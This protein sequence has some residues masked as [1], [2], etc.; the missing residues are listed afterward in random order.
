MMKSPASAPL[1]KRLVLLGGGHSHLSVLKYLAMHPVPG[2]EVVLISKDIHTPYSGALP[3][4]IAGIYNH[5]DIHIDLRP[6]AQF[7]GARLIREEI[8]RIDLERQLV[9]CKD[10]PALRFDVLSINIGSQPDAT[11]IPGAQQYALGVKPMDLFLQSW[12]QV[13]EA[14][15][16]SVRTGKHYS[17]AIVGGGPASVELAFSAQFRIHKEA[18]IKSSANSPLQIK[19]IT[20]D[21]HLLNS[22][23]HKVQEFAQAELQRRGI[24]ILFNHRVTEFGRNSIHC[25]DKPTVAAD[26]IIY[27]TGASILQWPTECGLAASADGFIEV[28]T[29]LQSTSHPSVFACGDAATIAGYPRPKSGVFAVRHGRPLAENLVRFATGRSLKKF[30]PQKHALALMYT[31]DR[32]AIASK[33]QW[34]FHGAWVWLWKDRIDMAFMRKYAQLP[35]MKAEFSLATG[36]TDKKTEQELR[37]HAI[38]CMGCAAKVGGSMLEN[39]LQDLP[40]YKQ[41]NVIS[42]GSRV[43]D[44]SLIEISSDRILLQSVDYLRAFINDPWLFAR[45]ATNH[46]LSDIYAMGCEPHSALV[47]A[48]VPYAG[49]KIMQE[50]FQELMSGCAEVLSQHATALIGGHSTEATELGLGLSVNG[51]ASASSIL[52]KSGVKAGDV[53]ILAKSLGTGTLLAADMRLKAKGR[54]IEAALAEMLIS[55]REAAVCIRNAKAHA[56]TDVTGFGLAGHLLEMLTANNAEV[57]LHL[58][59]L[60]AMDGALNC[61]RA[62]I[63]SS[64]QGDNRLSEQRISNVDLFQKHPAYELLFDPQTSGGLLASVPADMADSCVL[65]LRRS[66]Y[67]NA[68]RIGAVISVANSEPSI[69]LR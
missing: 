67:S 63:Q 5:D 56:C 30:L 42:S 12:E 38:R 25:Q 10:R 23:N 31:G 15:T 17:V 39:V 57:E 11:K 3:G 49:K 44:A 47:I 64:L 62:G 34:F 61:L 58:D 18:G 19:I 1:V 60:P 69:H 35:E 2:L 51:F 53:L 16:D 29:F 54:W 40:V 20:A 7:A 33:Q 14:A 27:A 26:T 37:Q 45:I 52:S 36:L 55:N 21:S 8:T 4:Y 32:K 50:T 9:L 13:L 59:S 68:A 24:E 65:A 66:G 22:H 28:N 41:D 43:E 46:C 48:S 6:L